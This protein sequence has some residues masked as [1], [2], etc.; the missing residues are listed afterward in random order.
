MN[1][2]VWCVCDWQGWQY[3]FILSQTAWTVLSCRCC[4][5]KIYCKL[6]N[7]TTCWSTHTSWSTHR[8]TAEQFNFFPILVQFP[9]VRRLSLVHWQPPTRE[10]EGYHKGTWSQPTFPRDTGGG[11]CGGITQ[12]K[13]STICPRLYTWTPIISYCGSNW[14]GEK[15]MRDVPSP[16]V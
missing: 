5:L 8:L 2:I 6:S 13:N 16:E 3:A 14:Q 7:P 4:N 10:G 15:D 1:R 11:V 12:P 9:L